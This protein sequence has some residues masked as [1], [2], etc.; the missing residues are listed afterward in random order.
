MVNPEAA[1]AARR[2]G[3]ELPPDVLSDSV[4]IQQA[5]GL[6]RSAQATDSSSVWVETL[7]RASD[8]AD[9]AMEKLGGSTDLSVV[10]QKVFD[11]ITTS[12][13]NLQKLSNELYTGNFTKKILLV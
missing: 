2:L 13:A 1:N 10:S 5:A 6:T 11:D 12:Q 4:L 9:L 3:I 7:R 8:Q